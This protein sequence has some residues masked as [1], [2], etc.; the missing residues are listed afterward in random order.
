MKSF[1]ELREA[2]KVNRGMS[3]CKPLQG[4]IVF[5]KKMGKYPVAI[6]KDKDG[7]HTYIDGDL[8]DTFRS[9]NDAMKA[10]KTTLKALQ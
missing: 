6:N 9:Q 7:F 3:P 10:I 4:E 5:K 2:T 1:A 8:L